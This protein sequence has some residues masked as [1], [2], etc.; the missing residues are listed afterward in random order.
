MH[1]KAWT[2]LHV[3]QVLLSWILLVSAP[4][5]MLQKWKYH[6]DQHISTIDGRGL[7]Q[8]PQTYPISVIG[9]FSLH[10]AIVGNH[11]CQ[12]LW[13]VFVWIVTYIKLP[14]NT[15]G[16]GS[17]NKCMCVGTGGVSLPTAAAA[18]GARTT[19]G[20]AAVTQQMLVASGGQCGQCG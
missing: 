13:N 6:Y 19:A 20:A 4:A 7:R 11:C 8:G 3:S 14:G 18:D 12:S 15:S 1:Y 17:W 5:N 16:L 9:L 2:L 10:R